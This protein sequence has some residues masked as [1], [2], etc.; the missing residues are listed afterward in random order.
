MR[1]ISS[2]G[3]AKLA[4]QYGTEP[5][6]IVEIDW[7]KGAATQSYADRDL[8]GP[9]PIPGKIV[10]LGDLDDVLDLAF[11]GSSAQ[12]ALTLDDTDGSLKAIFDAY[13]IY[14]VHVRIYQWFTGLDLSDKFLVFAGRINTPVTWNER[15]R[16][17]KVTI[18]SPLENLEVGFS[19][20]EGSFPYIP[21]EMIGKPW[22]M[23]FGEVIDYAALEVNMAIEG[24]TLDPVGFVTWTGEILP[25][26]ANGTDFDPSTLFGL[27]KQGQQLNVYNQAADLWEDVDPV[28]YQQYRE[29]AQAISNQMANEEFLLNKK[30]ACMLAT[31][32]RQL[33]ELAGY[34]GANP[35]HILGGED[36][37]QNQQVQITLGS[38]YLTGSFQGELFTIAS[39]EDPQVIV[40]Y[41]L[42]V[43]NAELKAAQH[44]I[45]CPL[46]NPP[47]A[48]T[49]HFTANIPCGS[50]GDV[51]N[52]NTEV[53]TGTLSMTSAL[54]VPITPGA[55]P[56]A[57]N[58]CVLDEAVVILTVPTNPIVK[59]PTL[60]AKQFWA[61][62]GAKVQLGVNQGC[63]FI[64]S[65]VPG[66][67]LCVKAFQTVNGQ[68]VLNVV[69]PSWY[70]VETVQYGSITA[71]QIVLQQRLSLMVY[72]DLNSNWITGWSDQLYV[73]FQSSVGPNIV[74][75]LEYLIENY[76][77]LTWDAT[78][79]N[80]CR[81]MLAP[82]PANFP[83]LERKNVLQVLK[84]IAFQCRCAIWIENEVVY[85]TYLPEEPTPV[86]TIT[87]SDIDSEHGMEIASTDTENLVTKMNVKW[88]MGYAPEPG[89]QQEQLIVLRHNVSRYGLWEKDY[90]WWIF[91]Q[92]DIILKMATFWLIRYSMI[93][94][95][96]RF[97][98]FLNKLNLETFDCVTFDV[99]GA[100]A[101][102]AVP[103]LVQKAA[104]NS[105]ENSIDFECEC[106]VN[107][108]AMV[109]F[110]YYWPSALPTTTTWPPSVTETVGFGGGGIG[111][112]ANGLLPVGQLPSASY[113][114]PVGPNGSLT[115]NGS[116]VPAGGVRPIAQGVFVGGPNVIFGPHPDWGDPTPG[117]TGFAAQPVVLPNQ[118]TSYTVGTPALLD[119]ALDYLEESVISDTP[120]PV[121]VVIDLSTTKIMDSKNPGPKNFGY[122]GDFF[123]LGQVGAPV[124][125]PTNTSA[126]YALKMDLAKAEAAYT[127]AMSD[128]LYNVPGSAATVQLDAVAN[129]VRGISVG[130]TTAIVTAATRLGTDVAR[131]AADVSN[132]ALGMA[133]TVTLIAPFVSQ[134]WGVTLNSAQFTAIQTD[135]STVASLVS[136]I[137]Y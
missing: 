63:N 82:F 101:S 97:R 39:A 78:S 111:M 47:P 70:T 118:Y 65:I 13:D 40:R 58:P 83:L 4:A 115:G 112:N 24:V 109:Q 128:Y 119:L 124:I 37:P 131:L 41:N 121:S 38:A 60:T 23:V 89:E 77:D 14:N 7:Y 68:R 108:G 117:D 93:W 43:A 28:Q 87:V 91:N 136:A 36:F 51:I 26:Y 98:A 122:L 100:V 42:E 2:N 127:P 54:G 110:P 33:S 74:D 18:V 69:P 81:T 9:P 64:A 61:D 48:A 1:T 46:L 79:F 80:H 25:L 34:T 106:P 21:S 3:L 102:A 132:L 88:R 129:V 134:A 95:R 123:S 45:D 31:R 10:D 6:S 27:W 137:V 114:I 113:Y 59:P 75:I 53:A 11:N 116:T 133:S 67:V 62:A 19:V 30:E 73:T 125:D 66:Q 126:T 85:L 15:D 35:I 71:V 56:A 17:L 104:Y 96:I 72:Q 55:A 32:A 135:A 103:V 94:K 29:M 120:L 90:D 84:D 5:I 49:L 16:T 44:L 92:P 76:T 22:P 107:A 50:L 86:D 99:P 52:F 57:P 105:A 8:P 12:V 130:S 20:E